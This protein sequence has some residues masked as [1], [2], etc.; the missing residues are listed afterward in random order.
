[1]ENNQNTKNA[2][3]NRGKCQ[4]TNETKEDANWDPKRGRRE[5]SWYVLVD[6]ASYVGSNGLDLSLYPVDFVVVSF[7]KKIGRASCRERV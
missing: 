1:M 2:T 4:S 7:Y 6:A 5:Y 3:V